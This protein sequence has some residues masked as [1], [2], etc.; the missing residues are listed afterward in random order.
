MLRGTKGCTIPDVGSLCILYSVLTDSLVILT[1]YLDMFSPL[2]H[3][4]AQRS[5]SPP[6]NTFRTSMSSFALCFIPPYPRRHHMLAACWGHPR[7]ILLSPRYLPQPYIHA[8]SLSKV[9]LIP[10]VILLSV[11]VLSHLVLT[12][13][14]EHTVAQRA[15]SL[16]LGWPLAYVCGYAGISSTIIWLSTRRITQ[17]CTVCCVGW[18]YLLVQCSHICI[19]IWMDVL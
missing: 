8:L 11:K 16:C 3:D 4:L 18:F 5:V 15:W 9:P 10:I 19:Y 6:L 2:S 7:L 12:C 17:V 13:N 14:H 1:H